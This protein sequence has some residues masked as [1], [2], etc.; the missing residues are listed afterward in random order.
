[1][2][3]VIWHLEATSINMLFKSGLKKAF[4]VF[5]FG[6]LRTRRKEVFFAQ[7]LTNSG[8]FTLYPTR[9]Q[10]S[11]SLGRQVVYQSVGV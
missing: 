7:F 8:Q 6:P 2:A 3:I 10:F 4:A 11:F 9:E 5:A 1:V